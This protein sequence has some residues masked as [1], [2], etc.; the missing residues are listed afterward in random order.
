MG[1]IR[2]L[3]ATGLRRRKG[4]AVTLGLLTLIAALLLNL[5][6]LSLTSLPQLFNEKRAA[7]H[8]PDFTAVMPDAAGAAKQAAIKN[9]I[10]HYQGVTKTTTD[11]ALFFQVASI[12]IKGSDASASF[13][14]QEAKDSLPFV[15]PTKKADARSAYVPYILCTQGYRLGDAIRLSVSGKTY[16]FRIAGFEEDLLWGNPSSGY[17]RFYLPKASYNRFVSWLGGASS[18]RVTLVNAYTRTLSDASSLSGAYLIKTHTGTE[19]ETWNRLDINNTKLVVS[20]PVTIG[21]ALEIAFALVVSLIVLLMVRFHIADSI[22]A[23]MRNIGALEAVGFTGGQIRGAFLLQFLFCALAGGLPGIALS[24]LVAV[25][26][27]RMLAAETGLAWTEGFS[28]PVSLTALGI[29]LGCVALVA[30]FAARRIR[31][32]PVVT[33]LRGGITTHSFRRNFFPLHRSRGPLTLLLA[34]KSALANLRQNLALG[35][36]FT[37]VSFA[38]VFVFLLFYN[39]SVNDTAVMHLMGGEPLDIAASPASG[40]DITALENEI[41]STPHITKVL[42]YGFPILQVDGKASYGSVT[43]DFSRLE[44]NEAYTGRYPKHDN[45][46]ALGGAL[47]AELHKSVGDS[48]RVTCGGRSAVFLITG[49]TQSINDLGTG[50]S[51]TESAFKKL[52]PGYTPSYLYLYTGHRHTAQAIKAVKARFGSR[53][54]AISSD[55]YRSTKVLLSSYQKII[56]GFSFLMFAV[57]ALIVVLILILLTGAALIRRRGELGIQKALGFTTRQLMRQVALGFLPVAAAGTVAGG[58]LAQFFADPLLGGLFR[59]I[60]ILRADFTFPAAAFP[61]IC[62]IL[63]AAAYLLTLAASSRIRRIPPSVLMNE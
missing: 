54:S 45:E 11:H 9:V 2:M 49:L 43:A 19:K 30:W 25:F 5:G 34:C 62:V 15:G 26:H 21:S 29:L 28:A 12:P 13:A 6:L 35:L 42:T 4:A 37:A 55:E 1:S 63:S 3:A 36:I 56:S 18:R 10:S 41:R 59:A 38:S 58:I 51:L 22:E 8:T 52:V 44:N 50:S 53:L 47:A 23:D 46:I 33:A 20:I 27:S 39:F 61:C 57:M 31:K 32:L 24:Y 14:V 40:T 48:V 17:L 60:G 7:L 16:T